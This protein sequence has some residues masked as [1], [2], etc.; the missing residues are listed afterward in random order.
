MHC[1]GT[2]VAKRWDIRGGGE[3]PR[4]L[5]KINKIEDRVLSGVVARPRYCCWRISC[6][7]TTVRLN[8]ESETFL[9]NIATGLGSFIVLL[10]CDHK[11]PSNNRML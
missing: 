6:L 9:M 8:L 5:M 1:H 3:D 10:F 2:T 11:V 4:G 7:R